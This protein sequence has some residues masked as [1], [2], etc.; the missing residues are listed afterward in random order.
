MEDRLLASSRP[1]VTARA[2]GAVLEVGVGT[3]PNLPHYG[4]EVRLTATDRSGG[5]LAEARSRAV[6]LARPVVLVR[7]DV[8]DLPFADAAFDTVV[9]TFVLCEVPD[10]RAAVREM[11]RV[12]R[13]G[14]SMLLADHVVATARWLR[15]L[16]AAVEVVSVPVHGEHLRRRPLRAVREQGLHVVAHERSPRG[17]IE[18]LHARTRAGDRPADRA[19]IGR[20]AGPGSSAAP[21]RASPA[22]PA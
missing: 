15:V 14:G 6:G 18:R 17:L 7:A 9:G 21:G 13:P 3:G 19:V 1:W 16:Q 10:E 11:A 8:M 12:L 2:H 4:R 22:R 20:P 5:M